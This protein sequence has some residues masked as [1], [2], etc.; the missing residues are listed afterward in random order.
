MSQRIFLRERTAPA[1]VI[2]VRQE[3]I[4]WDEAICA[5]RKQPVKLAHMHAAS[6]ELL[7]VSAAFAEAQIIPSPARADQNRTANSPQPKIFRE[8]AQSH[9]VSIVFPARREEPIRGTK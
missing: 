5:T 4:A 7:E 9:Q 1:I 3:Y 8:I 2:A 6:L